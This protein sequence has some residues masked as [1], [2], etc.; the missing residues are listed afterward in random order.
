[1]RGSELFSGASLQAGGCSMGFDE[2][3]TVLRGAVSARLRWF[4]TTTNPSESFDESDT[5][6]ASEREALTQRQDDDPLDN[7]RLDRFAQ[8]IQ[9]PSRHSEA[10][11]KSAGASDSGAARS[12]SDAF[13]TPR[14]D[15]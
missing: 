15:M 1:T 14:P 6:D 12:D 5:S 3:L 2:T 7:T 11:Q 9:K 4:L 13:G 8:C 10:R